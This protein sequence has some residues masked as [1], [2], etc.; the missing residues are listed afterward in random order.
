MSE[1][2][3]ISLPPEKYDV[4]LHQRPGG[5]IADKIVEIARLLTPTWFTPDVPDDTRR[6]LLFQDALCVWQGNTIISFLVFTSWDGSLHIT[7]FGTAP[8]H[9][10]KGWG[11]LLVTHFFE[12]AKSIGSRQIKVL[13]VPPDV[14]PQYTETLRFYLNHGFVTNRRISNLWQHDALE[15]FKSLD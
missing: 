8:V 9:R 15:L 7:L 10:G 14:K 2:K 13:T 3:K 1:G 5:D 12:H 6:D 4:R 11:S